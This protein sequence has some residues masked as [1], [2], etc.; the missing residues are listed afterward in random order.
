MR[1]AWVQVQVHPTLAERYS[2]YFLSKNLME[3]EENGMRKSFYS[4]C[5]CLPHWW[6]RNPN[7]PSPSRNEQRARMVKRLWAPEEGEKS[8]S[9]AT[10]GVSGKGHGQLAPELGTEAEDHVRTWRKTPPKPALLYST[11]RPL[12]PALLSLPLNPQPVHLPKVSAPSSLPMTLLCCDRGGPNC[13]SASGET[14]LSLVSRRGGE[15]GRVGNLTIVLSTTG[16]GQLP[17]H[18]LPTTTL[19]QVFM[20][21]SDQLD[22]DGQR[23]LVTCPRLHGKQRGMRLKSTT[24]WP[25]GTRA[26]APRWP[27]ERSFPCTS[28][29]NLG[30]TALTIHL[31]VAQATGPIQETAHGKACR[32]NDL[33]A[34]I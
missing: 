3:K 19:T 30:A 1:P 32:E 13:T 9:E 22:T 16:T 2:L 33:Q 28:A 26:T 11:G 20:S 18:S 25:Y 12:P 15:Q 8:S 7:S 24:V 4:S 29:H 14:W 17:L 5:M 27:S 23:G 10:N 31:C 6:V 21:W 34:S